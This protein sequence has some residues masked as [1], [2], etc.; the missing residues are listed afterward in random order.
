MARNRPGGKNIIAII[1]GASSFPDYKTLDPSPTF[2]ASAAAFRDYLRTRLSL[3]ETH[4]L[5]LFDE[6]LQPGEQLKRIKG[7]IK[8]QV[9]ENAELSDVIFYYCGHGA[10]L[11]E[12]EYVLALKC[13][14]VDSKEATV[15]K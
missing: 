3:P 8:Q 13:T 12:D 14:D 6:A 1:L 5:P 2:A 11:S 10:Y 4:I 15:F 9:F 7:F